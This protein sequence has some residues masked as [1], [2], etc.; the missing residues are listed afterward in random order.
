MPDLFTL[1]KSYGYL[2]IKLRNIR[3]S[4]SGIPLVSCGGLAV[5]HPALGDNG[6]RFEPRKRST[7]FQ[8][9]ISRLTTSWVNDHAKWR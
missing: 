4:L 5:K 1:G 7:L 6:H 9:L 2:D 8:R 3:L